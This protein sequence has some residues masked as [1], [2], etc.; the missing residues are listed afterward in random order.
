MN[1]IYF[2]KP[3]PIRTIVCLMVVETVC[4]FAHRNVTKNIHQTSTAMK[5]KRLLLLVMCAAGLAS[6]AQQPPISHIETNNVRA[7]ILGN[8]TCFV[9]QKPTF[10]EEWGEHN[11]CTTW[12]V[13]QGSGKETI[14][15]HALWLGGLDADDSLHLSAFSYGQLGEEYWSGPLKTTDASIDLMTALKYHHVWNLTRS[16]IEQFIAHHGEANYQIS[17]DIL[18]WPAHG[19]EGYAENMAPFVD[20]NSDGQYNPA[21]GDYPDIKGDQC[22]F[23]IF[24]DSWAAHTESGGTPLGLEVQ[25]MVYAFDAPDDDALN[26]TVFFNYKFFNRSSCNYHEVYLGLWNDWDIGYG[27]D[28]YVGCDVRRG[29]CFG[30]N[31]TPVDGQ[32]QPWAYGDNPPVQICTI[33]A[34]PYME[35]DGRDNPAFAG[36]CEALFDVTHPLD[37]YAYNGCNFGNGIV[38]D[39][40]LG[41]CGFMYAA[42]NG[43]PRTAQDYYNYLRGQWKNGNHLQY[44]GNAYA[45]EQVV[46]PDCNFIF[47]GDTDPCNFGTNGIVPNDGYNTEGKYWTEE[48]CEQAPNDR[49][50]L[51]SVGP[52]S[53]DSGR[54]QELDYAMITVWKND[55]QSALE[56]KGTIIDHIRALFDNN[57]DK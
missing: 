21:D 3:V 51:A 18:T 49:T 17:E 4:S 11:R 42:S 12:E 44:G 7:T 23:F 41:L 25:A 37:K 9:P 26:N 29:S 46:G 32:G 55:S 39:E 56:R 34:G 20:I 30:Y 15:Q 14:F 19:E 2:T 36:D 31:G 57:F 10:Y 47:P 13:P 24:N 45:G 50:G 40:R 28:D 8:G 27:W 53:F 22:L 52:F 43:G 5:N 54:M 6:V 33:L 16:E 38:D 1:S 35:A 48:Q